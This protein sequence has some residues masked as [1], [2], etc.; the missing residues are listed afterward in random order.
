[1]PRI[2]LAQIAR[3]LRPSAAQWAAAASP[4][5][6]GPLLQATAATTALRRATPRGRRPD[7]LRRAPADTTLLAGA[8]L[9]ALVWSNG[10]WHATYEAFW[11]APVAL[12]AGPLTLAADLRTWIDEAVMTLFF[13]VTGLEVK[14]ERDLGELR[15][16]RRLTAPVVAALAG[17]AASVG[18]Y[19]A[20]TAGG[21]AAHGWGVALSTDS[22]LALGSLTLAAGPRAARSRVFLLTLLVV[23]DVVALAAVSVFYPDGLRL[24][25]LVAAA[26][27]LIVMLA[28][29]AVAARELRATGTSHLAWW[30]L[31]IL[32]A[33]GLWIA[34]FESGVDPV[35]SGLF[36]GLLTN[37]ALP[38]AAATPAAVSPNDRLLALLS[39]WNARVV[40]PLFALANAGLH[41]TPQLVTAAVASPLTW[42]IVLAYAVA[43]PLGV[44]LG[45]RAAGRRATASAAAAT[46]VG[47]TLALL[48][49]ER[50]FTGGLLDEAKAGILLTVLIAPLLSLVIDRVGRLR[51]AGGH[52]G[53]RVAHAAGAV[54]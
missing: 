22:A 14:R 10:P 30:P 15:D 46:G 5:D 1:M 33:V 20:I 38:E 4:Q 34:L 49:A 29:R 27:L 25:A 40:V 28:I 13:L 47:F 6:P 11:H 44:L 3:R 23:D 36:I 21:P 45:A 7:R 43:K 17:I 41:V 50:A 54:R 24:T 9:L 35:V 53:W 16:G 52:G 19:L 8:V 31:T 37:A 32:V 48:I 2:D 39:P 26:A 18:V 12:A 51:R 42:A